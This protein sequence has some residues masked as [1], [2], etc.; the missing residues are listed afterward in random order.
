[1]TTKRVSFESRVFGSNLRV[2][3]FNSHSRLTFLSIDFERNPI[4]DWQTETKRKKK[5]TQAVTLLRFTSRIKVDET[6]FDDGGKVR[7]RSPQYHVRIHARTRVYTCGSIRNVALRRLLT[8]VD[9]LELR[10]CFTGGLSWLVCMSELN[11]RF[12]AAGV[13]CCTL[14][15]VGS[16]SRWQCT[17]RWSCALI[18]SRTILRAAQNIL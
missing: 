5:K 3:P 12:E 10:C 8:V 16:M 17:S 2:R 1:M 11:G 7:A 18:S 9:A 4:D 15:A 13:G 14:G 6:N